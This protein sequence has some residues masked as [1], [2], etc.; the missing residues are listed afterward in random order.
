MSN[1]LVI[2]NSEEG[3]Q[4]LYKNGILRDEGSVL[5]EGSSTEYLISLCYREHCH[6][7]NIFIVELNQKDNYT[8]MDGLPIK[9]EEF[10]GKDDYLRQEN[11]VGYRID[12]L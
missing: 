4:G 7:G 12:S 10:S 9:F 5:G 11:S 8:F 3:W 1:I 6:I 2:V